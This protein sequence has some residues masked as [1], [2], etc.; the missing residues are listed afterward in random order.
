MVAGD[1]FVA[2]FGLRLPGGGERVTNRRLI[3]ARRNSIRA[4]KGDFSLSLQR[5]RSVA[6]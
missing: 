2:D 1:G 3:L 5:C 6:V 4:L